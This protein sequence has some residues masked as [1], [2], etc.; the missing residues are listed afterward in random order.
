[1]PQKQQIY[2]MVYGLPLRSVFR[3]VF[4]IYV[5]FQELR[6]DDYAANRKGPGQGG[7]AAMGGL[8]MNQQ[9]PA[10]QATGIF[11]GQ[12]KPAFCKS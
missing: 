6:L 5:I 12:A 10:T 7:T 9:T 2:K 11:G 4:S 1:M 3:S 8:F